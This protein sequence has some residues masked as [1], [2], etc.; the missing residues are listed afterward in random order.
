MRPTCLLLLVA[1]AAPLA[2]ADETALVRALA[3][4]NNTFGFELY[5]RLA[6]ADGNF[7]CSPYSVSSAL[8]MTLAGARGKTAEEMATVLHLPASEEKALHAA[9]GALMKTLAS[10]GG[11]DAHALSIANALWGQKGEP[12]LDSFLSLVNESYGAGFR[13]TDFKSAPEAALRTINA[14]VEKKT[15]DKIKDLLGPE[16]LTTTSPAGCCTTTGA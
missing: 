10:E 3:K 1:W 15:R 12:F 16:W 5:A 4:S 7:L 6:K 14:W 11:E 13:Q 8:A 2:A 9:A